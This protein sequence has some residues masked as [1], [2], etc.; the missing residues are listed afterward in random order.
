LPKLRDLEADLK[1]AIEKNKSAMVQTETSYD[2]KIESAKKKK[3]DGDDDT[4][5]DQIN[6]DS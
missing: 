4:E 2:A 1:A 6:G 3:K 5:D